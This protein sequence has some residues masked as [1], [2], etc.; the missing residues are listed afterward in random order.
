MDKLCALGVHSISSAGKI[1]NGPF[2]QAPGEKTRC[3][4]SG[5]NECI[6]GAIMTT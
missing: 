1:G 2:A 4:A 3:N 6:V 5:D